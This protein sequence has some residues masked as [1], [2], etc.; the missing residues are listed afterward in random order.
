MSL[1]VIKNSNGPR[2]F[3]S[4]DI[5]S[6]PVNMNSPNTSEFSFSDDTQQNHLPSQSIVECK[7]KIDKGIKLLNNKLVNIEGTVNKLEGQHA[8]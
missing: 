3:E 4:L 5:V 7:M 1:A 8:R 2:I 6:S